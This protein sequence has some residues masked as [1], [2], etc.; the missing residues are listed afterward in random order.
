[1][2]GTHRPVMSEREDLSPRQTCWWN[3]TSTVVPD[4]LAATRELA[5]RRFL[6]STRDKFLLLL[7]SV[8]LI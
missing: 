4:L 2:M 5:A 1:M 8:N 6:V 3:D 7:N